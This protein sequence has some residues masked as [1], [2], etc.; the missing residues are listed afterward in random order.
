MLPL[1]FDISLYILFQSTEVGDAIYYHDWYGADIRYKKMM[2]FI[3]LRSQKP[4]SIRA[5]TF[6]PTSYETFM[7]I[8]TTSYKF[9][10]VLRQSLNRN[11]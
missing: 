9:F 5:P 1:L 6:P 4:A 8:M 2:V 7:R 11:L 10:A 3:M